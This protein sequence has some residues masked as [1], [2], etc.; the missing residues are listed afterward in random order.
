M[1]SIVG[2]LKPTT[3]LE[4]NSRK[5]SNSSCLLQVPL[6][7][8]QVVPWRQK[9]LTWKSLLQQ[10]PCSVKTDQSFASDFINVRISPRYLLQLWREKQR[11]GIKDTTGSSTY[12]GQQAKFWKATFKRTQFL[13]FTSYGNLFSDPYTNFQ[14][15]LVES[16]PLPHKYPIPCTTYLKKISFSWC[17]ISGMQRIPTLLLTIRVL[18]AQNLTILQ[19]ATAALRRCKLQLT[20]TFRH[21]L[22]TN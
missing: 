15:P 21:Q 1:D 3:A 2:N 18:Q 20:S 9:L 16:L 7:L 4:W 11:I 10:N 6:Y 17:W 5:T 8:L 22:A 12:K 13:I 19:P 14:S